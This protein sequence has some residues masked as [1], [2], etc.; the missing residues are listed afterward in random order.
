[1]PTSGIEFWKNKTGDPNFEELAI[2]L[3]K[4]LEYLDAIDARLTAGGL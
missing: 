2:M 4:I 3:N 1:M